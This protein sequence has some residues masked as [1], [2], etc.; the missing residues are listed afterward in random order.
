MRKTYPETLLYSVTP[1]TPLI[2]F[3]HPLSSS[4]KIF[5]SE[6]VILRVVNSS[7]ICV[8]NDFPGEDVL[9]RDKEMTIAHLCWSV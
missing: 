6:S 3:F 4:S 9:G 8:L 5:F 2:S 7:S 1:L